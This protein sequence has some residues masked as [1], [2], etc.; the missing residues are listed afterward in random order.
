MIRLGIV[1]ADGSTVTN[2]WWLPP[3]EG[4]R[5]PGLL[6][7]GASSAARGP[8]NHRVECEYWAAGLP[9]PGPLTFVCEWPITELS[10]AEVTIG[11]EA[12]IE[13]AARTR[14]VWET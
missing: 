13:A 9:P 8:G 7:A 3:E 1:F 11:A 14:S 5:H 2:C 4:G 12:I 10:Q 6:L